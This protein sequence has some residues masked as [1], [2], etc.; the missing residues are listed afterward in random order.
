MRVISYRICQIASLLIVGTWIV[1]FALSATLFS[2]GHPPGF[3]ALVGPWLVLTWGL[4]AIGIVSG[5]IAVGLNERS[6]AAVGLI[7]L[8]TVLEVVS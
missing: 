5:L 7:A 6:R 3:L 8:D 1:C 4:G 2:G